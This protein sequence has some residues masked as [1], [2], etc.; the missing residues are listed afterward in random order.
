MEKISFLG[1]EGTFSH[2]AASKFNAEI[3]P[4][5]TIQAIMESIESGECSKGLVP[6]ENSLEGPVNI[7]LDLLAHNFDLMIES[8]VVISISHNLLAKPNTKIEDITDVYSHSQALAQCQ[9]YIEKLNVRKHF[10]S[11]TTLAAEKVLDL[12]NAAAIGSLKAADK[13]GL[14]VLDKNIQIND[15]NETRFVVLSKK[16]H[17]PTGHDKTSILFSLFNDAESG[18]LY[19]I[20]KLFAEENINLTKIESRP[21]KN[22]LGTYIFFADLEGHRKD[23]KIDKVLKEVKSMT[24]SFKLLGSYPIF[25]REIE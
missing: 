17:I 13:Y 10:T 8:E 24:S 2:E 23:E 12:D 18:A 25:L 11:S 15:D 1:P 22:K 6:I 3:I 9:P 21:S 7:T 4:Y 5:C 16:D 20:L 14:G 19:K